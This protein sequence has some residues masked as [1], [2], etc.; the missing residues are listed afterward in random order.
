MSQDSRQGIVSMN[1]DKATSSKTL[2]ISMES[3]MHDVE[4]DS[5]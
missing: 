5:N 2:N 3:S 4:D 1:R